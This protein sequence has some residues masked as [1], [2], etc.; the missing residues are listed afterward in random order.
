MEVQMAGKSLFPP[1]SL[2]E[3]RQIA[4]TIARQYSGQ[5]T[6]RLDV[7]GAL[8]KSPDS[9]PSRNLVTSSS[10]FGLTQGG[11]QAEMLSLT[12]LGKRLAVEGDETA[13]IDAV[14][15]VEI[16]QKF[17]ENCKNAVVPSQI[18]AK[19]FLAAN[20]VPTDRTQACFE[21]I[22]QNGRECGLIASVSG[23]ERVL[24]RE[25]AIEKKGGIPAAVAKAP[26]APST[27]AAATATGGGATSP[28]TNSRIP[29]IHVNLEIHLPSDAK[30]DVYEA[31]FRSMRKHLLDV[32]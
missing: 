16:F 20:G 21:L 18:A 15:K 7:F 30:P 13:T 10:G 25:H 28:A 27:P 22:L 19:S 4:D 9:G 17:F 29:S 31:I 5:P 24:S 6:R 8:G 26:D 1:L 23:A 11:Y 2:K 12:E 3:A 32:Q 14:L